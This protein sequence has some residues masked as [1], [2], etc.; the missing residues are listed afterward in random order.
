VELPTTTVTP[1]LSEGKALA[2][3][4]SDGA[5]IIQGWAANFSGIDR[6]SENFTDGAFHAGIKSFLSGNNPLC[7]HH[8]KRKV[9]GEVLALSEVPNE[10]LWL[11]ARVDYQEPGSPLRWIYNAIKAGS[12]KGLSVGGFFRRKLTEKGLR[13]TTADLTEIS[14][15]GVP[16]HAGA[17]FSIV[18]GKALGTY[19]FGD[20]IDARL[21]RLEA[22]QALDRLREDVAILRAHTQLDALSARL[23]LA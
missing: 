21:D 16:A 23:T 4:E 11:K 1:F 8:D 17:G 15:V 3:V 22:R 6:H 14:V 19:D 2:T 9:I 18:E 20:Y 12:M 10:G 5:L 13:I 7:F